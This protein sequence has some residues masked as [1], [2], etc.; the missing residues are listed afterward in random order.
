MRG[1][2][3]EFSPSNGVVSIFLRVCVFSNIQ[4]DAMSWCIE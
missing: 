3:M 2:R 4:H 1:R